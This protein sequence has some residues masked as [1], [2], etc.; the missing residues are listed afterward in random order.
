MEQLL[1]AVSS[2]MPLEL[3][4]AGK[5]L[6]ARVT[7]ELLGPVEAHVSRVV[8]LAPGFRNRI[9]FF[10]APDAEH[11]LLC[12]FVI[13]VL[14]IFNILTLM[15][16]NCSAIFLEIVYKRT[17]SKICNMTFSTSNKIPLYTWIRIQTKHTLTQ[18]TL[19]GGR[20]SDPHSCNADPDLD[21]GFGIYADL[22]PRF[23][24][25]WDPDL[26]FL[27]IKS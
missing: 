14:F 19:S 18:E 13:D 15:F 8:V 24:I 12:N 3:G 6:V 2:H 4:P 11:I 1:G 20:V 26:V 16:K 21:L 7:L 9:T 23:Q 5:S 22:D 17:I 27:Y 10:V 25:F